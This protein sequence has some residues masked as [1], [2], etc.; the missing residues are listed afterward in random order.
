MAFLIGS[1]SVTGFTATDSI[2]SGA[3][4][5]FMPCWFV[6]RND[7]A[8]NSIATGAAQNLHLY[9]N[10]WGTLNNI[11]CSIYDETGGGTLV[12][13]IIVNSSVGTGQV[14]V[15]MSGSTTITTGRLYR[16]GIYTEDNNAITFWSD[17]GG[18]TKREDGGINNYASPID[19]S[20]NGGYVSFNEYYWAVDDVGGGGGPTGIA[21]L[22]RRRG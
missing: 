7:D 21:V 11:K 13:S 17:T 18:K 8:N 10:S 4:D 22:R 20:T 3:S 14:S 9:I 16:L 6:G 19:P 15:A 5:S 12:E 2:N 1:S